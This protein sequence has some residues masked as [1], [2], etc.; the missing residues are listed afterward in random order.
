MLNTS[1]WKLIHNKLPFSAFPLSNDYVI[2]G[3]EKTGAMKESKDW[4]CIKRD[5]TESK[6]SK[7]LIIF[8]IKHLSA[9]EK[10]IFCKKV[11]K[12]VKN[13]FR[14]WNLYKILIVRG[15]ESKFLLKFSSIFGGLPYKDVRYSFDAHHSAHLFISSHSHIKQKR[16]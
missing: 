9:F 7:K 8:R 1:T 15:S 16:P 5:A 11:S 12:T 4:I 13:R 14:V 6:I 2:L 3:K 10:T